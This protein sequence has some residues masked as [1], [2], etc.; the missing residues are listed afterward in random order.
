MGHC[1]VM[2]MLSYPLRPLRPLRPEMSYL[3]KESGHP[4][5]SSHRSCHP[6]SPHCQVGYREEKLDFAS[7]A[8]LLTVRS[9]VMI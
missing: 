1:A 6:R 8:L 5:D 7:S 2:M 9:S 4:S 3:L